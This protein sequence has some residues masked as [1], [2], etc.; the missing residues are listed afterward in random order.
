MSVITP[1]SSSPPERHG[2]C[3]GTDVRVL[4]LPAALQTNLPQRFIGFPWPLRTLGGR[5][6]MSW[7]SFWTIAGNKWKCKC[8]SAAVTTPSISVLTLARR[9]PVTLALQSVWWQ[10]DDNPTSPLSPFARAHTGVHT[11]IDYICLSFSRFLCLFCPGCICC[12]W[13]G[14]NLWSNHGSLDHNVAAYCG[15]KELGCTVCVGPV[16]NATCPC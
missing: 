12:G 15:H 3:A 11:P 14:F 9:T 4:P 10:V 7:S 2:V 5:H 6:T 8:L 1:L 16:L 13:E